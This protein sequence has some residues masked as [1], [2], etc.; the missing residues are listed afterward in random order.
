MSIKYAEYAFWQTIYIILM[1]GASFFVL[2]YFK[3]EA[4]LK[5]FV[6]L[7]FGTWI[8]LI[9]FILVLGLANKYG[10]IR[11]PGAIWALPPVVSL[12]S[13]PF[14]ANFLWILLPALITV[15]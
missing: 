1:I 5:I 15:K 9:L 2:V 13:I 14:T 7:G 8:A 10:L 12:K 11:N 3:A 6:M 4:D